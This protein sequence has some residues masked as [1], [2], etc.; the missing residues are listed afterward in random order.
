M[1]KQTTL[2]MLPIPLEL[3]ERK[4]YFLRGQKVMLDS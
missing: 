1:P 4:I 3:I 2:P